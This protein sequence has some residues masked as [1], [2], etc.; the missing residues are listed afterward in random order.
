MFSVRTLQVWQVLVSKAMNRQT[1]TYLKLTEAVGAPPG[2][3]RGIGSHHLGPIADYCHEHDLP[4]LSVLVVSA[5]TGR[6]SLDCS[7]VDTEREK[8]FDH[9]W[10]AEVPPPRGDA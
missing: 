8:V 4:R 1:I 5:T 9:N 2:A 10:F 3:H 7:D 6:P